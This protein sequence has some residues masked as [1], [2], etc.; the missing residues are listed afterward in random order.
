MVAKVAKV[1]RVVRVDRGDGVLGFYVPMT[2]DKATTVLIT[3]KGGFRGVLV[4][5]IA[6]FICFQCRIYRSSANHPERNQEA[7]HPS[8]ILWHF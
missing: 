4:L 6:M 2:S 1:A 3:P 8:A 5:E 7:L